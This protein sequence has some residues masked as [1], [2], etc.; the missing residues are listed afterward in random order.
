MR[1]APVTAPGDL[2]FASPAGACWH[3]SGPHA[4]YGVTSWTRSFAEIG[5]GLRPCRRCSG[6]DSRLTTVV[7]VNH[8][9]GFDLYCGRASRFAKNP[10]ARVSSPWHNP[11]RIGA[12]PASAASARAIVIALH[13]DFMESDDPAAVKLRA[14]LHELRGKRLA[15]WCAPVDAVLTWEDPIVCHCQ[16]LARLA[17]TLVAS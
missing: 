13:A 7:H 6:T 15:C 8:P 4:G 2:V 12:C 3:R 16:T 9:G 14:R 5:L 11:F 10:A 17:D 1:P